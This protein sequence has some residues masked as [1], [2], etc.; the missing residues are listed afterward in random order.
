MLMVL[1][2]LGV[3]AV[4][5]AIVLSSAAVNCSSFGALSVV[6]TPALLGGLSVMGIGTATTLSFLI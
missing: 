5:A 6:M 2:G 4:G 1:F 3:T